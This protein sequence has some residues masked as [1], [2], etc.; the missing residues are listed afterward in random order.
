MVKNHLQQGTFDE[1]LI[2]LV[3]MMPIHFLPK[4]RLFLFVLISGCII[5]QACATTGQREAGEKIG[6]HID[7]V[8]EFAVE[9]PLSW[10]KDRR[11]AYGSRQG[12]VR[13]TDPSYPGMLL[14]VGSALT[15]QPT[16]SS[17]QQIDQVL[18]EYI[19]LEI[20]AKQ[21]VTLPSGEAWHVTGHSVQLD[22]E[23]YLM[24]HE[25]RNY[26]ISLA[27]PHGNIDAYRDIMSRIT[28]SFQTMP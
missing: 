16:N 23:L 6:M 12:E 17:E 15:K 5:L 9:Y 28:D 18:Q 7:A 2:D 3:V 25:H 1:L 4:F 8:L 19:G 27:V 13:W 10:K 20:T 26:L 24:A 21:K 14:K 22:L 11:V